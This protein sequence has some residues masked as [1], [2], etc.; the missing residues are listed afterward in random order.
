MVWS[1]PTRTSF[2]I[3]LH[4]HLLATGRSLTML[5]MSMLRFGKHLPLK[6]LPVATPKNTYPTGI[7]TLKGRTLGPLAQL[8]M[9]C[10]RDE[11]RPLR[12]ATGR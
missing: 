2:S 12:T 1:L 11:A 10:A 6:L 5:P 3:P 8:F 4:H 7:V 9:D